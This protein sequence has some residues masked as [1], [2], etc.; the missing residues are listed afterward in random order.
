MYRIACNRSQRLLEVHHSGFWD[1][2]L[3]RRFLEDWQRS[4]APLRAQYENASVLSDVRD[5]PVQSPQVLEMLNQFAHSELSRHPMRW[6]L[7]AKPGLAS[8]QAKRA[9]ELEGRLQV[10]ADESLAR[11]WLAMA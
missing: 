4:I 11:M 5:F 2:N 9:S 8:L 3:T 7:L 10:F 1:L 6:A